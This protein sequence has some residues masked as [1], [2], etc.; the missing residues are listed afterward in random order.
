MISL[1]KPNTLVPLVALTP[2]T[3]DP[4]P[5]LPACTAAAPLRVPGGIALDTTLLPARADP[6]GPGL[7]LAHVQLPAFVAAPAPQLVPEPSVLDGTRVPAA[8]REVQDALL[9][10]HGDAALRLRVRAE[11]HQGYLDT[12]E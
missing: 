12:L 10:I 4:V 5:A 8:Q 3:P 9:E 1:L 6:L 11:T 2:D 7:L